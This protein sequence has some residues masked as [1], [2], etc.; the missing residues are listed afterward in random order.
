MYILSILSLYFLALLQRLETSAHP[1]YPWASA[2]PRALKISLGIVLCILGTFN[3][4]AFVSKIPSG[5]PQVDERTSSGLEA[6]R[7]THG[8]G[9]VLAAWAFLVTA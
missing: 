9:A 2:F 6:L 8:I 1:A 3:F 4:A 7:A 5:A